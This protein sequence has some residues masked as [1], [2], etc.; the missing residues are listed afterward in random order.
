MGKT[1]LLF[2]D[3]AVALVSFAGYAAYAPSKYATRAFAEALRNELVGR[4]RVAVFHPGNMDSP[5]YE[6][7]NKT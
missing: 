4:V 7:E 1:A 6:N 3:S 2:V 5:G